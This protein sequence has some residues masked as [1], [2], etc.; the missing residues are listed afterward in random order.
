[1]SLHLSSIPTLHDLGLPD[2]SS[3]PL[4]SVSDVSDAVSDVIVTAIDTASDAATVVVAVR[5]PPSRRWRSESASPPSSC[6]SWRCC[7]AAAATPHLS[8][9]A[10]EDR[11]PRIAAA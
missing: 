9:C 8:S 4:P 7:C 2:P 3:L 5:P 11:K 10:R 1:M 6:W